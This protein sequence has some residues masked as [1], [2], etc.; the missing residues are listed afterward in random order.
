MEVRSSGSPG[1]AIVG[2]KQ[3][4]T[5]LQMPGLRV[6]ALE[7]YQIFLNKETADRFFAVISPTHHPRLVRITEQLQGL[8]MIKLKELFVSIW[9]VS[10]E[11]GRP[12][13]NRNEGGYGD[14]P[15]FWSRGGNDGLEQKLRARLLGLEE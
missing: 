9:R 6:L 7:L 3:V 10:D 8:K 2:K 11:Q 4:V 5:L 1:G 13:T 15:E 14:R 12:S